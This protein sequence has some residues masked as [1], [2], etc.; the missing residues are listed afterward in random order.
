M[1]DKPKNNNKVKSSVVDD[2]F[3]PCDTDQTKEPTADRSPC[4]GI[5]PKK[6]DEFVPCDNN[7]STNEFKPCP[8]R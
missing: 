2:L 4:E 3:V 1:E 7:P 8:V 5:A 6:D